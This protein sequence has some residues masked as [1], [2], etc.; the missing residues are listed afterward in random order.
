MQLKISPKIVLYTYKCQFLQFDQ[1]AQFLFF[2]RSL[3]CKTKALHNHRHQ[4]TFTNEIPVNLTLRKI[5]L[6]L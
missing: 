6:V 2:L 4:K 5:N 3:L 1:T